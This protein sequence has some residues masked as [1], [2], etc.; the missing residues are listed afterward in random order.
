VADRQPLRKKVYLFFT[1]HWDRE[2]YL[3]FQDFRYQLVDLIDRLI[4]LFAEDPS[5]PPFM[6]DGQYVL[7]ED[8]LE[9][10]P[11]NREIL[12]QLIRVGKI[13][14]GP[15]YT[16][17]DEI[18]VS[19]ESL[20]RNLKIGIRESRLL[21]SDNR[22]G[23]LCDTFGHNSQMPQ[24]L[25]F[26]GLP[27]ALLWRGVDSIQTGSEF[28]WVAADGTEVLTHAVP[29]AKG[30]GT[31]WL[32]VIRDFKQYGRP[33]DQEEA[34]E[35]LRRVIEE[36]ENSSPTGRIL[37]QMGVDHCR[38]D[39]EVY[40]F[41]ETFNHTDPD[42]ELVYTTMDQFFKDYPP[43]GR[44]EGDKLQCVQ[45]ELREPCGADRTNY[46]IPYVGSS[47]IDQKQKSRACEN[48]L[49]HFAEPF[50]LFA[51][52]GSRDPEFDNL[53]FLETAWKLLL[54]NQS[55]DSIC[56]CSIDQVHRD[57]DYRFDQI[58]LIAKRVARES[59]RRLNGSHLSSIAPKSGM[60]RIRF[61]N[62]VGW[63]FEGIGE[64][65]IDFIDMKQGIVESVL[66]DGAQGGEANPY[67]RDGIYFHHEQFIPFDIV[68]NDGKPLPYQILAVDQQQRKL[69]SVSGGLPQVYPVERYRISC[70]LTI[71][72][73]GS[74]DLF[75]RPREG[76]HIYRGTLFSDSSILEN[77]SLK[78]S[79]DA[80]STLSITNKATGKT[81]HGCL[82][83][84]LS[85]DI[86]DGYIYHHP[87]NGLTGSSK[88]TLQAV[89][90]RQNG[91]LQGIMELIYNLH[92]P[93]GFDLTGNRPDREFAEQLI[94]VQV[95]IR[96]GSR[97][98]EFLVSMDN[99]LEQ[100][101][102][103]VLFPTDITAD[104]YQV[105]T[106]FDIYERGVFHP[107]DEEHNEPYPEYGICGGLVFLQDGADTAA[108]LLRG[109]PEAGVLPRQ[110]RALAA[111]LLRSS[112]RTVFTSG[113]PD[114][115]LKR[116][117][118][119]EFA[120]ALFE[121]STTNAELVYQTLLYQ[122]PPRFDQR[123][124]SPAEDEA[125]ILDTGGERSFVGNES[126]FV[127]TAVRELDSVAYE[128]RG[129]N[130]E[131]RSINAVL[132]IDQ[133]FRSVTATDLLGESTLLP[134]TV[135]GKKL[136]FEVPPKRIVTL[137]FQ[138]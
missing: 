129:F 118:E 14:V 113:Q 98:A 112:R 15:W 13:V 126:S 28:L 89:I 37:L 104:S 84:L 62:G 136:Q 2:W 17:P 56:G 96:K 51:A 115:L 58:A 29:Q 133:P 66:M 135:R 31:T 59:F 47:R 46:L 122:N 67:R 107:P 80:D 114:G 91:P 87:L 19:G 44:G 6:L 106:P 128:L 41:L 109:L 93:R 101:R 8:Y 43:G 34:A 83:F 121:G 137:V 78:V 76:K 35:Q 119:F 73:Y 74:T 18:I 90:R 27:Y 88:G 39:R 23:Y 124:F 20:V 86:G 120:L 10:R 16:L 24:I 26:F 130:P 21:G 64:F 77:E 9:M 40:E 3:S 127:V 7:V 49:C 110:D 131:T 52:N 57:M 97:L 25:N 69:D 81:Y 79:V 108:L 103:Q 116:H 30:Y 102:L 95:I 45:D 134:V 92:F 11:Y 22:C 105:F 85:T 125:H 132:H 50:S 5:L 138:K 100:V 60:K 72:S 75:V 42:Y 32:T 12:R 65:Q 48:L 70:D 99:I 94:T 71:P 1:T 53:P 33:I 36:R 55:H 54:Q 38:I 63:K 123:D 111:T 82:E 117:H 61:Y 68:T 4:Q